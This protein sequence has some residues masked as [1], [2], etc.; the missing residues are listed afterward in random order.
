MQV[1]TIKTETKHTIGFNIQ[2]RNTGFDFEDGYPAGISHL[3]EHLLWSDKD[4]VICKLERD[5]YINAYTDRDHTGYHG[6]FSTLLGKNIIKPNLEKAIDLVFNRKDFPNKLVKSETDVVI[7][8]LIEENNVSSLIHKFTTQYYYKTDLKIRD[9]R[10]Q[11]DN[12]KNGLVTKK[13]LLRYYKEKYFDSNN[14][15]IFIWHDIPDEEI[16]DLKIYVEEIMSKYVKDN[17]EKPIVKKKL[18]N[19]RKP[20]DE[21]FSFDKDNNPYNI[22]TEGRD[23][24]YTFLKCY[25]RPIKDYKDISKLSIYLSLAKYVYEIKY[26]NEI[27]KKSLYNNGLYGEFAYLNNIALEPCVELWFEYSSSDRNK[28]TEKEYEKIFNEMKKISKKDFDKYKEDVYIRI[29]HHSLNR[30]INPYS[31]NPLMPIQNK[32]KE[33][34]GEIMN[35]ITKEGYVSFLNSLKFSGNLAVEVKSK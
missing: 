32:T 10:I 24:S 1:V 3:L 9:W 8:E 31:V 16:N 2:I 34:L 12:L 33:W 25:I 23:S 20:F 14:I 7:D 30:G 15:T 4:G 27:R 11:K 6:T 18:I 29:Y 26:Y 19:R 17:G 28:D 22:S 5:L 21:V 13:E 35:D